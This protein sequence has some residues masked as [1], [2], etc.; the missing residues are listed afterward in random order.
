M[1]REPDGT[2][3]RS[4]FSRLVAWAILITLAGAA[5]LLAVT[6]GE[7]WSATERS[8]S[9]TV[10]TDIAGLADIYASGGEA[11]LR[12]RLDDRSALVGIEGRPAHYLLARTDGTRVGGDLAEWPGLS[13]R[14]SEHG[15]IVL[16]SGEAVYARATM[17]APDLQLLVARDYSRDTSL[18]W[19][20]ALTFAAAAAAIALF[21]WL[22]GRAAASTLERRVARI[23]E[24]FRVFERGGEPAA[25][26]PQP[27]DEIGELAEHSS[28]SLHRLAALARTHRHMSD[29]IAHEI[30]TPLAHLDARLVATMR[31]LPDG[32][33]RTPLEAARENVRGIVSMLDSLLD[34]A[35]SEARVGDPAGLRR[36]DLSE[37]AENIGELY[38]GSAED[39]GIHLKCAV[40]PGVT[41]LGEATQI[42]RLVSNLLDNALKHVPAGGRIVLAVAPGPVIS[43]SDD[44]PGIPEAL[45]PV[46]FDRFRSG[47]PVEGK[48][49][50]GLGLAL[51]QAIA[52]RHDM[53]I[54]LVPSA[55]G[56]Q[57]VVKPQ[58]MGAAG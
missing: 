3:R 27:R 13:A 30:R 17:L 41:M 2:P 52:L 8:L 19:R 42:S 12:T 46:I 21:V 51:A 20:L 25:A 49:S 37:L 50:H 15:F 34:I 26:S 55:Q 32:T 24:G 23:N 54:T 14:N 22:V 16:P 7:S 40:E 9:A 35:A 58:G 47:P 43:V 38:S 44:G 39:A 56:A 57:F 31:C 53:T 45:R 33:D 29:Q 48:S 6:L 10:D 28:R 18:L 1:P 4:I 5:V 11:E 36:F